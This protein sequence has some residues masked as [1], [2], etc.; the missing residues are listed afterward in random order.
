M[1]DAV[2]LPNENKTLLGK[3]AAK[4]YLFPWWVQCLTLGFTVMIILTFAGL[5]IVQFVDFSKGVPATLAAPD[6]IPGIW[7]RWDSGYYLSISKEGYSTDIE[8]LKQAA[9]YFPLYPFLILILNKLTGIDRVLIGMIISQICFLGIC[10]M[11]YLIARQIK[12]S[13]EFALRSTFVV[14]LFPASFFFLAIYA[15]PLWMLFSLIGIY[16]LVT[17]Q[18]SYL[19]AGAAFCVA[20]AARPVGWLLCLFMGVEFLQRRDFRVR[21]W[22]AVA[23]GL[24]LSVSST[25]AYV[26][27]LFRLTGTFMAIPNSQAAWQRQWAFPWVTLWDS[28]QYIF[29]GSG[30]KTDWFLYVCN[31]VDCLFILFAL[32]LAVTSIYLSIKGKLR[33]SFTT[34]MVFTILFLL[35]SHGVNPAP[36]WGMT[37][38]VGMLIPIYFII[39]MVYKNDNFFKIYMSIS[40]GLLLFFT[41]WWISGR[42]VG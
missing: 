16:F 34:Y 8:F 15:E 36:L 27:Y 11:T 28:I 12:D 41:M 26:L 4:F 37:R 20:A 9:G 10:V 31:L 14:I 2:S 23:G 40:S 32:G 33:W 35:S 25:I 3:I 18:P 24:V 19:K 13:H 29:A 22:L 21:S 38:W 17:P 30:L 6:S 5:T 42:W 39:P 1:I 7:A